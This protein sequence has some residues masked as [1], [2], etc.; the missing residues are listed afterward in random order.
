M[1]KTVL[2]IRLIVVT[3]VD[4][5]DDVGANNDTYTLPPKKTEDILQRPVFRFYLSVMPSLNRSFSWL[6]HKL[7][8]IILKEIT[9]YNGHCLAAFARA[10]DCVLERLYNH[11]DEG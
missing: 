5:D 3:G 8:Q 4:D 11:A 9:V 2:T 10:D 1:V 6:A 7:A